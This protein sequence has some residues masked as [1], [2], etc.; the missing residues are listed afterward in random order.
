MRVQVSAAFYIWKIVNSALTL[1]MLAFTRQ[2][3]VAYIG[4]SNKKITKYPRKKNDGL[5]DDC[6]RL[7]GR[8]HYPEACPPSRCA[9]PTCSRR[10]RVQDC[11]LILRRIIS[12]DFI[13]LKLL[14]WPSFSVC[15]LSILYFSTYNFDNS[16]CPFNLTIHL[17]V[18]LVIQFVFQAASNSSKYIAKI[19]HGCICNHQVMTSSSVV[20]YATGLYW[21]SLEVAYA[22]RH[23]FNVNN[24]PLVVAY[25][26]SEFLAPWGSKTSNFEIK[27]LFTSSRHNIQ[28]F[29]NIGH[30]SDIPGIHGLNRIKIYVTLHIIP[31]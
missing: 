4:I 27:S 6:L 25:A 30:G 12:R 26:T 5:Q 11:V 24:F 28:N 19:A 22:T 7:Q 18:I 14:K 13:R 31:I 15:F 8:G 10:V 16:Q 23:N 20:A 21:F 2:I 9:W 1:D 29:I 3:V 17:I